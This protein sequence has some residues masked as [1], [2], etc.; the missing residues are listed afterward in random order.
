MQISKKSLKKGLFNNG[1]KY[2]K[3]YIANRLRALYDNRMRSLALARGFAMA[4]LVAGGAGFIGSH[5]VD[6]MLQKEHD[7]KIVCFDCLTYAGS[8][9]NLQDAKSYGDRF[10]F[11]LGDIADRATVEKAFQEEKPEV[12]VNFAA[13]SHVDRSIVSPKAFLETNILGTQTLMDACLRHG[14]K[15]FHQVSTDEVYGEAQIGESAIAFSEDAPLKPGNPYSASKAGADLL[16]MAYMR[17]FGLKATISRSSNVYG[18]RQYPEKLIPVLVQRAVNGMTLPL[19][20]DGGQMRDWLHVSDACKAIAFII[21]RG[22]EGETYNMPGG[23]EI[24]N[25]DLAKK[26]CSVLG[27]EER[28]EFVEDRKGHDARY[29]IDGQKIK[30]LG[31]RVEKPFDDGFRETVMQYMRLFLKEA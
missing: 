12:V 7:L 14:T 26:V 10:R 5:F 8:M 27:A 2:H 28:I 16:V 30:K 15:R 31:W 21:E 1:L 17:T 23:N 24:R 25:I 20:G 13:E 22:S 11:I 4:M 9:D 18:S 29:L 3:E 19:Y 6:F